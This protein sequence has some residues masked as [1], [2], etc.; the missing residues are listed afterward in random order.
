MRFNKIL[1]VALLA[2]LTG[3]VSMPVS[4]QLESDGYY[5]YRERM[6]APEDTYYLFDAERKQVA[7]YTDARIL[8]I[9]V[10]DSRH[11]VPLKVFHDDMTA[12]VGRNDC[13]RVEAREV[14]LKPMERLGSHQVIVARAQTL[15]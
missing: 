10:G 5:A 12:E 3:L 8:R 1:K 9:C 15:N 11:A 2:L 7:S 6:T 4:G 13:I 14:A